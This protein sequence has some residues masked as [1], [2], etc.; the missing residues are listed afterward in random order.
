M[1]DI[2]LSYK[3]STIATID[4][5]CS[6][7]LDTQGKYCEDDIHIDYVK[8]GGS[9]VEVPRSDVNF[10]D[11]DG[12][13]LYSYTAADALA[14]EALPSNPSHTGLTAQGWN[15]TLAE[16]KTVV[17]YRGK[18]DIGQMYVT[19][20]GSTRLYCHFENDRRWPYLGLAVD[21]TVSI[22]W[23][24]NTELS[25]LSGTS[26]SGSVKYIRHDYPSGGDYVIKITKV[27][28]NGFSIL[29]D[30]SGNRSSILCFGSGNSGY[31]DYVYL[32][33][34]LKVE[35][36]NNVLIGPGAFSYCTSLRSI[37]IPI[38]AISDCAY[39]F[40]TCNSL[41]AA[42]F[43][44]GT[45][46]CT[47]NIFYYC[48]ALTSISIPVSCIKIGSYAFGKC[49]A[50]HSIVLSNN[51][52]QIGESAFY[53]GGLSSIVLPNVITEISKSML[54]YEYYLASLVVPSSVTSIKKNAFMDCYGLS[55]VHILSSSPPSLE[56][57]NAF[58]GTNCTIY[59]PYSS[60]HSILD[61][62]LEATN[63]ATLAA[64]IM[65]EPQ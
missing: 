57:T 40:C 44:S 6:K 42:I 10:M 31:S 38:G 1:A 17:G 13:V 41:V 23:G 14:L 29:D 24:D 5:S 58:N 46:A 32:N 20:D 65:E 16:M 63:W 34:L 48:R 45:A 56:N 51:I 54:T 39:A 52:G 59:V 28:G 19:S 37:S 12:K 7:K 2:T 43:P 64:N 35:L 55:K 3:G 15:Y 60:D 21:G 8:P 22:D 62:Y 4:E 9:L 25:T 47:N 50:L 33:A 30:E 49:E 53:N 18:C 61:A 26:M 11:Y 27:S 36:G